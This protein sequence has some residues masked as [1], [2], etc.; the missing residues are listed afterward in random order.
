[1]YGISK[2]VENFEVNDYLEHLPE[3]DYELDCSLGENPYGSYP[4]I[5]IKHNIIDMTG[6]YPET[7]NEVVESILKRYSEVP[8]LTEDNVAVTSGSMAA[9]IGLNR[10]FMKEGKKTIGIAP[11]FTAAVDDFKI[12]GADYDP[13]YL[14]KENNFRFNIDEFL[15]KVK[16]CSQAYIYIDNPNNPTGQVISLE[17]IEKIAE[18]AEKQDSFLCID[19]AYGDYV[20]TSRS[21]VNL[22][23]KHKN[24][25][26]VR[27]LSK[28]IGG[29]GIRA[30]YVFSNAEFI[31]NFRKVNI[32]FA[33]SSITNHL[34]AQLL[35]SGWE[36]H[37]RKKSL[38]NK[39]ILLKNLENIKVAETE[40]EVPIGLYYVEDE[41]IDLERELLKGGI[42]SV[43]CRR[44]DGL[45][46]NYVRLNLH[47][48]FD[49]MLELMKKTDDRLKNSMNML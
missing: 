25:A 31:Q 45:S 7:E 15:E 44:Y 30:G 20:D 14:K 29:A 36:N 16:S 12:Y 11:Q 9:L 48:D 6:S 24:I 37:A 35:N 13:V 46:Q 8:N 17:N 39:E 41:E 1:M 2:I 3:D 43:S 32:S 23:D 10:M 40:M 18:T 38:E 49:K 42:L 34:A 26:V 27:S 28:G 47:R 21:A 5:E 22:I 33:T 4:E 19:E